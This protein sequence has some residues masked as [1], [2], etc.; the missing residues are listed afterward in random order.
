MKDYI[1][2]VFSVG[3]ISLAIAAAIQGK[4][5]VVGTVIAGGFAL[6]NSKGES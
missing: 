2:I 3:I 1:S 6:L 4:W 5:E